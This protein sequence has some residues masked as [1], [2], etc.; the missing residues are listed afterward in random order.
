MPGARVGVGAGV[1]V[2]V[3]NGRRTLVTVPN[4]CRSGSRFSPVGVTVAAGVGVSVSPGVSVGAGVSVYCR[5]ICVI[6][7][8][9]SVSAGVSVEQEYR[10]EYLLRSARSESLLFHRTEF[11]RSGSRFSPVGVT[12][13]AGVGVSVSPGVSVEPEYP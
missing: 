9:V 7:V 4:F 11:C 3:G 8:G 5:C 6:G 10:P 12:V 1:P 13:A 2:I